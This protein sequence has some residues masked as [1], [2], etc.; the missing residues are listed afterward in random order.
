MTGHAKRDKL[1]DVLKGYAIWLVVYGHCIQY[2]G[3]GFEV[4]NHPIGKFIYLFH[5]PLFFF[6]SG[7]VDVRSFLRPIGELANRKFKSLVIPLVTFAIITT[8]FEWGYNSFTGVRLPVQTVVK[9]FIFNITQ[10]YW[11]VIVLIGSIFLSNI[12]FKVLKIFRKNSS[13]QGYIITLIISAIILFLIPHCPVDSYLTK[14]EG[15]Y[16]FFISGWIFRKLNILDG[17]SKHKTSILVISTML[18][19]LCVLWFSKDDFIY[20]LN[21]DIYRGWD[22]L[23]HLFYSFIKLMIG[24]LIGIVFSLALFSLI[25]RSINCTLLSKIGQY[26]L[27]IY[28]TQGLFFNVVLLHWPVELKNEIGYF[29]TSIGITLLCFYMCFFLAKNKCISQLTLG[30]T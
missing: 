11:F 12:S 14:L 17:I 16:P 18:L 6:M 20:F 4:L 29:I 22:N 15:M 7:Y 27:G 25:E 21:L 23:F 1:I 2:F 5:M 10:L 30:K 8:I 26:T 24:G 13:K 19:L 9:S 3:E 28:L